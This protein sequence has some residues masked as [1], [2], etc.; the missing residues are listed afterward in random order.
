MSAIFKLNEKS[1]TTKVLK[2]PLQ[3]EQKKPKPLKRINGTVNPIKDKADI[4]KAKQYY[5]TQNDYYNNATNLRN[6]CLFVFSLNCARRISDT[7]KVRIG[8]IIDDKGV[9]RDFFFIIEKK[10]GKKAKL[11]LNENVKEAVLRYL[12]SRQNYSL[13]DMLFVS[14]EGGNQAIGRRQAYNIFKKMG[15]EIGLTEKGINVGT[16]SPRKTFVYQN[17]KCHPNTPMY[18]STLQKAL[19]HSSPAITLTYAGID[20]EELE[21]LYMDNPL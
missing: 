3:P 14:R 1:Y 2:F 12:N 18:I 21:D 7:L 20:D 5:L 8:D 6:Y 16:H 17:L 10:T 19:N 15:N 9:V 13:N 4:E 11:F